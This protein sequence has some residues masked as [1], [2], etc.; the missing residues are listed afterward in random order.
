MKNIINNLKN[1]VGLWKKEEIKR[2]FIIQTFLDLLILFKNFIH[3]NISKAIISLYS[4]LIWFLAIIPF[5]IIFI[6]YSFFSDVNMSMLISGMFSWELLF[7]LFWNI[8]LILI[9]ITYFIV[10]S[11]SNIM[12]F[13]INNWYLEWE[14]LE[15]KNEIFFDYVRICKFIKLSLVNLLILITPLIIFWILIFILFIISGSISN[16]LEIVK[17]GVFNYFTVLSLLFWLITVLTISYLYY[18]IVFSFLLFADDNIYNKELNVSYYIKESFIKTKWV[19][20]LFKFS[21]LIVLFFI[22]ISP[23]NYVWQV[24]NNNSKILSDYSYYL[25]LDDNFKNQVKD[26][27]PYY[28]NDLETEFKWKTLEEI[29]KESKI[30]LLY[31]VLFNIFN[32]IFIY[33]L[34]MMVFSSFY[35][36]EIK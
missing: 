30:N 22:I 17:S 28:Y 16:A 29:N 26:Q 34:F 19:L 27:N 14:E 12:L 1:K 31:I 25:Q 10:F 35:K 13:R 11:Y 8:L 18:K 4:V 2:N 36:R 21:V 15:Y 33:W 32:F 20:K 23:F 3:W 5:V 6:I 24:L 7:D 9:V